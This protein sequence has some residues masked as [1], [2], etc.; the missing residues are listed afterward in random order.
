M[1]ATWGD[2]NEHE[3]V[4]HER[5]LVQVPVVVELDGKVEGVGEVRVRPRERLRRRAGVP[6]PGDKSRWRAKSPEELGR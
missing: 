5:Y 3:D 6:G 1:A 2:P 4:E